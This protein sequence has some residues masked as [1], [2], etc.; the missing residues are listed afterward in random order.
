[1]EVGNEEPAETREHLETL[2]KSAQGVDQHSEGRV[3]SRA[4][5]ERAHSGR[6]AAQKYPVL[7]PS[8]QSVYTRH[9][10]G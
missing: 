7:P 5:L 6:G 4:A 9:S 8:P 10:G 3:R 2:R 1:M